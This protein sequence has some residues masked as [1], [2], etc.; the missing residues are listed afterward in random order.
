MGRLGPVYDGGVRS[1]A[2]MRKRAASPWTYLAWTPRLRG[3][4]VSGGSPTS[5][6][7]PKRLSQIAIDAQSPGLG[8]NDCLAVM[9]SKNHPLDAATF[10]TELYS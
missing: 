8:D 6:F 2:S 9:A 7:T 4:A 5:S 1:S 3:R 10:Q